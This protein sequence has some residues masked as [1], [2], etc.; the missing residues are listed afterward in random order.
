MYRLLMVAGLLTGCLDLTLPGQPGP[1]SVTGRVV[2]TPPGRSTARPAAGATV[3][4]LGSG[5]TLTTSPEGS[6]TLDGLVPTTGV[7]LLRFDL[8]GDGTFRRQRL[9]HL[10][11]FDLRPNRVN[12]LPDVSLTELGAVTGTVLRGDV[13]PS[14]DGHA[15]IAV[16]VPAGPWTTFTTDEGRFLLDGLPEGGVEVAFFAVGL[17]ARSTG[18][19]SLRGGET[20]ELGRIVLERD[21]RATQPGSVTGALT[22]L[23]PTDVGASRVTLAGNAQPVD[24]PVQSSGAFRAAAAP[25]GLYS[26]RAERSG[27]TTALVPNVIVLPAETT[28]LGTLALSTGAVAPLPP[29]QPPPDAAFVMLEG[30]STPG[31]MRGSTPESQ[32]SMPVSTRACAASSTGTAP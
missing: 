32:S 25:P 30:R 19:L 2:Y 26:L 3:T 22:F 20:L 12:M 7:L 10:D 15:G 8:D 6:F 9:V 18:S 17:K 23:P 11:R 4:L 13:L 27:Y 24:A 1:G 28:D 31:S 21:P 5:L 29:P 16:F 14:A